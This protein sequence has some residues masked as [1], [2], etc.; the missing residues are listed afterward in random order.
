MLAVYLLDEV[1]QMAQ[2]G[3]QEVGAIVQFVVTRL[4]AKPPVVKQKVS[5][6]RPPP[7]SPG[8]FVMLLASSQTSK[9]LFADAPLGQVPL[10]QGRARLP[11]SN[12][13]SVSLHQVCTLSVHDMRC[14]PWLDTACIQD[15][16]IRRGSKGSNDG[17]DSAGS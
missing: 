9:A 8:R 7:P 17:H 3:I 14:R 15:M 12:G 5:H 2:G 13:A 11:A 1:L 10:R 4:T 16:L 6:G